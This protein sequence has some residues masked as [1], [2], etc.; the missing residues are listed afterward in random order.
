MLDAGPHRAT[1]FFLGW[2]AERYP[3]LVR[4]AARRGYEIGVHGYAHR[5]VDE[6]SPEGFRSDLLQA[7]DR[8]EQAAGTRA[9]VYRAAEW[10]IRDAAEPALDG[11]AS[12][13]FTC[14]A[15]ITNVPPLG[16]AENPAGPYRIELD[17]RSLTEIPPLTGRGF[18]R[19]IP[20]GGGWPFRM[21]SPER[22]RRA[23]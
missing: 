22:V 7:R 6:M 16:C 4:E 13:G 8:I 21:F 18:A 1:F 5:R 15:S 14:D 9:A 23:E 2:V 17:G 19:T 12:E 3:S 10:A 20:M 11:L